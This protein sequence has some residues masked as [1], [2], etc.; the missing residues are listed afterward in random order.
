MFCAKCGK[1]SKEGTKFC[2]YCGAPLKTPVHT[3]VG[4]PSSVPAGSTKKQKPEK[5]KK[6][7]KA[8][9]S[10]KGKIA[11]IIAAGVVI[12]AAVFFTIG[13]ILCNNRENAIAD[14][15]ADYDITEYTQQ[16]DD[17]VSDYEDYMFFDVLHK[18][19]AI[20]DLAS[21]RDKARKANDDLEELKKNYEEMDAEKENYDLADSYGKYE[22]SLNAWGDAIE[23]REY[24]KAVDAA[25][26]AQD[27]LDQLEKDNRMYVKNKMEQYA[28]VD[29]S[30]DSRKKTYDDD[31]KKVNDLLTDGKYSDMKSVFTELDSIA[32]AQASDD[33]MPSVSDGSDSDPADVVGQYIEEFPYAMT[34]EDFS[35]IEDYL[36]PGSQIYKDQKNYIKKGYEE[37]L[38]SYEIE[39][40]D[41]K[42]NKHCVVTSLESFYLQKPGDPL[43]LL[44]QRCKYVVV[45]TDGEWK[46]TK[47]ADS[48]EVLSSVEQ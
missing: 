29:W 43:K 1:E 12:L 27:M 40:V 15:I 20:Q 36:K 4:A 19:S 5:T 38:E 9:K 24:Q 18:A 32:A 26:D 33:Q 45:L 31:V 39:S 41:Y 10:N 37:T 34:E 16:K 21:V 46:I 8:K 7:K 14:E 17:M 47:Y 11:V 30:D 6:E 23:N 25:S 3:T 28:S 22:D 2:M 13:G 44:T 48:V 42:D 35:Y